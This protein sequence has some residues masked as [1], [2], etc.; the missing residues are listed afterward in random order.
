MSGKAASVSEAYLFDISWQQLINLLYE[1]R[2]RRE[3]PATAHMHY[4]IEC[5][6]YICV[7]MA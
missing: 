2:A 1:T 4:A 7:R 5:Y 3:L 6:L